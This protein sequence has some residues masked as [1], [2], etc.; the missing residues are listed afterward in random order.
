MPEEQV[1]FAAERKSR[2]PVTGGPGWTSANETEDFVDFSSAK[3]YQDKVSSQVSERLGEDSFDKE[4]FAPTLLRYNLARGDNLEEKLIRLQ[5]KHPAGEIKYVTDSVMLRGESGALEEDQLIYRESKDDKWKLVNRPG[6]D[7]ADIISAL[8]PSAEAITAEVGMALLTSG[9][10]VGVTIIRQAAAA[11]FGEAFEQTMQTWNDKQVQDFWDV[12]KEIGAEGM[13]S[14]IGGMAMSPIVGTKNAV[15]GRGVLQVG[16]SGMETTRALNR[17]GDVTGESMSP[18]PGMVVDNPLIGRQEAQAAV[19]LPGFKRFYRNITDNISKAI[20]ISAPKADR[21][22]AI[23]NTTAALRGLGN[24]FIQSLRIKKTTPT[25]GGKA[26]Q[27]GREEF[28]TV[29]KSIENKMYLAAERIESPNFD[30]GNW[31]PVAND[32]RVGSRGKINADVEDLLKQLEAIDGPKELSEGVLSVTQQYRNIRTEARKLATPQDGIIAGTKEGQAGEV[33]RA[34]NKTLDNPLNT[35]PEFTRAWKAAGESTAIRHEILDSETFIRI[36][37]SE[38]PSDLLAFARPGNSTKLKLMRD[39]LD[40]KQWDIFKHS[41]YTDMASDPK[42]LW[43]R[44]DE[45]AADPDTLKTLIPLQ[46]DRA[47]WAKVAKE[48]KRIAMVN[49]EEQAL[50]RVGNEEYINGILNSATPNSYLTIS[51]AINETND[52]AL[53]DTWRSGII[54][55][56]WDGVIKFEKSSIKIDRGKL[57]ARVAQ[58]SRGGGNG[59]IGLLSKPQRQLLSDIDKVAAGLE[60]IAD[61][62]T[63]IRGMEIASGLPREIMTLSPGSATAGFIQSYGIE[64]LYLSKTGRFL[65]IGTGKKNSRGEYLRILGGA[66]VRVSTDVELSDIM[67]ELSGEE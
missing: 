67:T 23:K 48:S 44:W 26:L 36:A 46:G 60:S 8:A 11:M 14:A 22:K 52:V 33:V 43:K 20:D 21:I 29:S 2:A 5:G 49:S 10:S 58:L 55:W 27:A 51:R 6:I 38:E 19:V 31:K 4:T 15:T 41:L 54:R 40:N 39:T 42:N 18:S 61:A 37:R 9:G 12:A 16:E 7:R 30:V 35:S 56:A 53:R 59:F 3:K 57:A 65:L 17:I 62:G 13:Y 28:D 1:D 45:L 50:I 64:K 32:L 34:I 25:E 24:K 66:M 47:A 63:S